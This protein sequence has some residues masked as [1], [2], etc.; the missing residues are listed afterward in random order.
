M[1]IKYLTCL[2]ST[3]EEEKSGPPESPEQESCP[4]KKLI[5]NHI[6]TIMTF[7]SIMRKADSLSISNFTFYSTSADLL[8]FVNAFENTICGFTLT[9]WND[10]H[11]QFF[12]FT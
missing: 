9:G 11:L 4:E 3:S 1:P 2:K 7:Y 10:W 12:Q 5:S 6:L 8:L